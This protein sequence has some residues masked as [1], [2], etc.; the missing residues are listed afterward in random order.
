M[1]K[2]DTYVQ[3]TL[4]RILYLVIET[5]IWVSELSVHEDERKVM[6]QKKKLSESSQ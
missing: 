5:S 3:S 2:N 6:L 1:Y 4:I